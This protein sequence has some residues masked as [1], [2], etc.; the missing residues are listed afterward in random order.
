M[1]SELPIGKNVDFKTQCIPMKHSN[2]ILNIKEHLTN[3]Y[4]W[5]IT[6]L[7]VNEYYITID[8]VNERKGWVYTCFWQEDNE[9]ESNSKNLHVIAWLSPQFCTTGLF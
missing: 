5:N 7:K 4:F 3:V 6:T 8:E 2:D 1:F 9:D